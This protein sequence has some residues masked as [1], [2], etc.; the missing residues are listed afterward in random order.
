MMT[1]FEQDVKSAEEWIWQ[2]GLELVYPAGDKGKLN[3]IWDRWQEMSDEDK[4]KSD[5]KSIELFGMDNA[6]HYDI[7]CLLYV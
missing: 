6:S 2:S 7:L 4:A 1:T 3:S 5:A